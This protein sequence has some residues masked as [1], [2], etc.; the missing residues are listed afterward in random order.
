[1]NEVKAAGMMGAITL[2]KKLDTGLFISTKSPGLIKDILSTAKKLLT[3]SKENNI[4]I[5]G[6]D[7]FEF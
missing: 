3:Y 4:E 7:D 5:E 2:K 6:A 1:M